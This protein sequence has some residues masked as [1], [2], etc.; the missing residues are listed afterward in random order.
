MAKLAASI[1]AARCANLLSV[2]QAADAHEQMLALDGALVE[3]M[4]T[5][6]PEPASEPERGGVS[7]IR[8]LFA[9]DRDRATE[10]LAELRELVERDMPLRHSSH[11][12]VVS[13][14]GPGG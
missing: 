6:T 3:A 1:V 5:P 12:V 14:I 4:T 10:Y 9:N 8:P 11:E 2:E 7:E 13:A